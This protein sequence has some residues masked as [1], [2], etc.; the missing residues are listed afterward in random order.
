MGIMIPA[1]TTGNGS[2]EGAEGIIKNISQD[3]ARFIAA[4]KQINDIETVIRELIDNS[5]DAGAKNIEVRLQRFGIECIEVD[6]NGSGIREENFSSLGKRYHTSKITDFTKF[7]ETLDTFGFRGEALSCLCNVANVSIITKAKTSPTGSRITFTKD[8]TSAKIEPVARDTGTTVIV[9]NLFHSLPVRKRE[10][11]TTAKRQYDKVVKLIYEHILARPHIKFTLVKKTSKKKEK[12]FAHGGTTLEGVIMNIFSVKIMD[13]LLPI[14]QVGT[15]PSLHSSTDTCDSINLTQ[16]NTSNTTNRRATRSATQEGSCGSI[17]EKSSVK[18]EP[19][20]KPLASTSAKSEF[21]R[22]SCRSKFAREKPVFAFYGYISKVN[23]GRNSTDCQFIFI[24]KKPC[25]LPKISKAINEIYRISS[26]GQHPFYCLFI[27]V[28]NW[29]A[30]FNVPRKRAVILQDEERL[31]N[32]IKDSLEAM[33]ISSAPGSQRLCPTADIPLMMSKTSN[34]LDEAPSKSSQQMDS[35]KRAADNSDPGSSGK[36]CDSPPT[37]RM[38]LNDRTDSHIKHSKDQREVYQIVEPI[39]LNGQETE[40][41][42]VKE[43]SPVKTVE[44]PAINFSE[45]EKHQ[46][47]QVY[48][49]S[50]FVEIDIDKETNRTSTEEQSGS[51]KDNN[52]DVPNQSSQYFSPSIRTEEKKKT[53]NASGMQTEVDNTDKPKPEGFTTALELYVGKPLEDSTSDAAHIPTQTIAVG[54]DDLLEHLNVAVSHL[55]SSE[56]EASQTLTEGQMA[57]MAS[58]SFKQTKTVLDDE[59]TVKIDNLESLQTTLK[60][61]R[62]QRMIPIDKKEFTFAIHPQ[63]NSVA[64]QQLRLNLNKTSFKNMRIIGQFNKG[65]II[66]SLNRHIFIVDQHATDERANYEDQLE[67]SPLVKQPMVRP[68]PLYFNLIQEN[69]ILNHL[70]AFQDRGFDFQLDLTKKIG[71]RVMLTSTSICKGHGLDEHLTKEDIEEL[72]DVIQ[73]SPSRLSS[74]TLKKVKSVAATRACRKS[75]MIGDKL[76]WSQMVSIVGRMADLKNPWVCAHG[77]PTIRHLMEMDWT[78]K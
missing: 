52:E 27:Q 15:E 45:V 23:C 75:V 58:E 43:V 14:P 21:F 20:E 1:K 48:S 71:F 78:G 66:V 8:G 35:G 56:E 53:S 5:I 47:S 16:S 12:D 67:K 29:A 46:D 34:R 73:E 76:T 62:L 22:R 64:E 40:I 37:K 50:L 13:S 4:G 36:I 74:Y 70:T 51:T 10:L 33:F 11:E 25:D 49:D 6:D 18:T 28:Q 7:Q 61:E 41:C 39:A 54:T 26:P 31:C 42:N 77:R 59:I 57:L 32:Q 30:D 3:D 38:L 2:S 60:Q 69:A 19:D 17:D 65:F 55:E 24:N 68:K 9:K 72:I 44:N 63:F